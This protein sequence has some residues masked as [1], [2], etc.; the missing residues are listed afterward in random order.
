MTPSKDHLS[1]VDISTVY[2][3][4]LNITLH[5]INQN[6]IVS[7]NQESMQSPPQREILH[8]RLEKFRMHMGLSYMIKEKVFNKFLYL[9]MY[10]SND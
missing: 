6:I 7:L 5:K 2:L 8:Y 9:D 1:N 3:G 10:F 4:I